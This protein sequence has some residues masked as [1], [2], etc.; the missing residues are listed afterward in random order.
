MAKK[1]YQP[2]FTDLTAITRNA[3]RQRTVVI[4]EDPHRDNRMKWLEFGECRLR[5]IEGRE[6]AEYELHAFLMRGVTDGEH[7]SACAVNLPLIGVEFRGIEYQQATI[8]AFVSLEGGEPYPNFRVPRPG[9]NPMEQEDAAPCDSKHCKDD[10][11]IIV[12]DRFYMPDF[13]PELYAA[14]AGRRVR[15]SIG[16]N[17]NEKEDEVRRLTREMIFF[18]HLAGDMA[19]EI[20]GLRSTEPDPGVVI[21]Q[22]I[23]RAAERGIFLNGR[24]EDAD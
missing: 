7:D 23:Q 1:K 3:D 4:L 18:R 19:L 12:S 16:P 20:R 22:Y 6:H 13:D 2:E 15:I 24:D 9:Y 17:P 11:H 8:T 14:V 5:R 21:K 10:P